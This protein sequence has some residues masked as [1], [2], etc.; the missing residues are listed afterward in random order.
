MNIAAWFVGPFVREEQRNEP[1]AEFAAASESNRAVVRA[2]VV[3]ATAQGEQHAARERVTR[4]GG[5]GAM[6]V[7]LTGEAV[8]RDVVDMACV[9]ALAQR[10]PALH[11]VYCFAVPRSKPVDD[12]LPVARRKAE[13]VLH[14]A[15][16]MAARYEIDVETAYVQARSASECALRVVREKDCEAVFVGAPYLTD[17][18]DDARLTETADDLLRHA[19]CRVYVVR[20]QHF[21]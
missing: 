18:G 17:G 15:A 10:T 20:G 19:P 2:T 16:A 14:E 11:A 9:A 8:D 6:W 5:H 13:E 21:A 1:P 7:V 12:E 4:T 3:R